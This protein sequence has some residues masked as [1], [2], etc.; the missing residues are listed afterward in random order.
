MTIAALELPARTQ[1]LWQA[2]P[3]NQDATQERFSLLLDGAPGRDQVQ[4]FIAAKFRKV[5]GAELSHFYPVIL[6]RADASGIRAAVGLRPGTQRP[7][8]LEQYLDISLEAAIQERTGADV[9]RQELLEIGNLAAGDRPA[10][11][12]LFILLTAVLAEAGFNWVVFTATEQIRVLLRRLRFDP[13]TLCEADPS[14]LQ[15]DPQHWG[16]YYD[17]CPQ[18]QAGFVTD[19]LEILRRDRRAG[20]LLQQHEHHIRRLGRQLGQVREIACEREQGV[21][22]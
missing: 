7:L 21:S 12:L 22:A 18:V 17:S 2:M 19:A 14:R 20:A 13:V 16:S 11:Q 6:N 9:A 5:Y 3:G 1:P 10:S 15:E 4:D 8:F